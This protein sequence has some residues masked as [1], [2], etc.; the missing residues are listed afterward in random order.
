MDSLIHQMLRQF[1]PELR[2]LGIQ[3]VSGGSINR[4]L[5]LDTDRGPFF[6][7][8]N[9]VSAHPGMFERESAGLDLLGSTDGPL[10]PKVLHC[11]TAEDQS[12][13]LLEWVAS[14]REGPNSWATFGRQLA[15]LHLNTNEHFGGVE[16]N[17]IGSLPQSNRDHMKWS[18]FFV[19]ERL[20][21]LVRQA[22]DSGALSRNDLGAFDRLYPK[23]EHLFPEE[24]PALIHGDLWSGNYMWDVEG[25]PVL[26]D[27]A[28]YYGHREMDIGMTF[29]F[30]GFSEQLYAHYNEVFPMESGWRERVTLSNLYPTLVHVVL[31]GGGY[32]HDLR[33]N[34]SYFA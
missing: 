10:I 22:R 21:P 25:K 33:S 11:G 18:D 2:I 29:M 5:R 1:D 31:F 8:H 24:P 4:A 32:V 9:S 14:G 15:A 26:I 27:P 6:L 7:K 28:V 12:F 30:G 13:L 16:D 3:P 34:M 19:E 17:Y 23:L 20:E